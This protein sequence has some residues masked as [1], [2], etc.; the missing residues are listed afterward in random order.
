MIL[1]QQHQLH[2]TFRPSSSSTEGGDDGVDNEGDDPPA[3]GEGGKPGGKG[4][5]KKFDNSVSLM[6]LVSIKVTHLF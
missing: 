1:F 4:R 6:Q 5:K 3:T 2:S